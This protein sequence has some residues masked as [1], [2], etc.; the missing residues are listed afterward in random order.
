[1]E[2][3]VFENCK[4]S[5]KHSTAQSSDH[6]LCV[7]LKVYH[8][9]VLERQMYKERLYRIEKTCEI[10]VKTIEAVRNEVETLKKRVVQLEEENQ[11][12]RARLNQN[13]Q[14]S[15]KPPSIDMVRLVP[16]NLREPTG[17]RPGGQAGHREPPL[18]R[19][20]SLFRSSSTRYKGVASAKVHW[21]SN[22]SR[23]GSSVKFSACPHKRSRLSNAGP[24]SRPARTAGTITRGSFQP[25]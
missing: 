2:R 8:K 10:A 1:M 7:P 16:K 15:S 11:Q 3:A 24:K 19:W 18:I 14:N 6:S 20:I 12:L 23:D 5:T 13:S 9:V 17:R 4:P 21:S 25:L 22:L